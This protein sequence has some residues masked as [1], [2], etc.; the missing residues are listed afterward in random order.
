L[1]FYK[2]FNHPPHV[3]FIDGLDYPEVIKLCEREYGEEMKICYKHHDLNYKKREFLIDALVEFK[4]QKIMLTVAFE[5]PAQMDATKVF[6]CDDTPREFL[7]ELLS[8]KRKERGG[9]EGYLE[10]ISR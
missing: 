2:R 10:V 4:E 9:A 1:N 5:L 7:D 6:Y 3:Y 8:C